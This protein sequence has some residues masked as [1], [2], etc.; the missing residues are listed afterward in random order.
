MVVKNGSK[1]K[2]STDSKI[3]GQHQ[4]GPGQAHAHE[5][6]FAIGG[7]ATYRGNHKTAADLARLASDQ[8]ALPVDDQTGLTG[9]CDV[10]L[11]WSGNASGA[12]PGGDGNHAAG[13][14]GGHRGGGGEH[15]P[16][17]R[18]PVD[19]SGPTL[20]EALQSQLG[21]KLVPSEQAVARILVIDHVNLV[22]TAN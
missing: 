3:A 19:G 13:G 7:S 8:L 12:H 17:G 5:G 22:P 4:A 1:L 14:A 18:P 20:F 6:L 10:A 2:E 9:K 16:A 11:S 15:G 21:L